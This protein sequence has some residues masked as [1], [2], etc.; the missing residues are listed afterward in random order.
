M[1]QNIETAPDIEGIV[2][3]NECAF[4]ATRKRCISEY[5]L[6]VVLSGNVKQKENV[7]YYFQLKYLLSFQRYSSFQNMQFMV[8]DSA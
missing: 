3:G 5:A 7:V 6:T 1:S 2:A 4:I 8:M